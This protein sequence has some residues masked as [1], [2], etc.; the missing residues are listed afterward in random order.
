MLVMTDYFCKWIEVEAYSQVK[1]KEVVSF[2]KKNILTRFGIPAEIICDNGSQF[3]SKRTTDFCT[4]WGIKMITSTPIY[5]QANG[6]AES[7]NKIIVNNLK[8]RL[9]EKKGKWAEEL[10]FVLW[11]DRTTAKTATCQTPYALVFGTEA[12]I[13][14]EVVI[15]TA[16]YLLQDPQTNNRILAEDLDTIDELRDLAKIRIAAHQ[17]RIAKSYNKN[18]RIRRF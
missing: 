8:K 13:P 5:P 6:Q 9:D 15:P 12:V 3:I 4:A 10:P 7:S 14:T 17:Q 2:I 16:R 1:D 11:A 18:I